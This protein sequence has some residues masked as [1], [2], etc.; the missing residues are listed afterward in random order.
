MRFHGLS[1]AK[2]DLLNDTEGKV[3]EGYENGLYFVEPDNGV[4][5]AFKPENL[6]GLPV[7]N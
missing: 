4:E 1:S 5:S 3:T 7:Y 2:G 6:Q